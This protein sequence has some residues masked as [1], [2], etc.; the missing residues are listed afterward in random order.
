MDDYEIS[1]LYEPK[2]EWSSRLVTI[3]TPLVHEGILSIFNES[4]A[5]CVDNDEEEK[6]LMTF[7]NFLGRIIKW[8][9]NIIEEETK[10]IMEKSK[11]DYLDDLIACVHIIHL[12]ALTSIRVSN[13]QKKVDIDIPN[14]SDF[15]HKVYI[16]VARKLY[17]NVY[18]FEKDISSLQYQRNAR[19]TETI[20]KECILTVIRDSI[21]VENILRAYMDETQ[22]EEVIEKEEEIIEKEVETNKEDKSEKE[23]EPKKEEAK[24]EEEVKKEGEDK[25]EEVIMD[26]EPKKEEKPKTDEEPKKDEEPPMQVI[27]KESENIESN[28]IEDK[29]EIN[30][31]SLT[32]TIPSIET[33]VVDIPPIA[34]EPTNQVLSPIIENNINKSS[35]ES[36]QTLKFN[37]NDSVLDMSTNKSEEISAPKTIERLEQ[38][39]NERHEQRKLEEEEDNEDEKIKIH[40]DDNISLQINDIQDISPKINI[41]EDSILDDVVVLE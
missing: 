27:P 32:D 28:V 36:S 6:Y 39:S 11:C 38:I 16:A 10:R 40:N 3:L 15:I 19:T 14:V 5:L 2:N 29:K 4:W 20:I 22:E 37:E 33:P 12:K 8:N 17:Q 9:K 1:N 34:A 24:K 35:N 30:K 41:K 31:P 26:E 23:E 13:K 25:K 18:L 7:Q 21:P